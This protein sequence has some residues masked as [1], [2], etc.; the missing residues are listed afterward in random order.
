[1]R[2]HLLQPGDLPVSERK[3]KHVYRTARGDQLPAA[4]AAHRKPESEEGTR[5]EHH[6]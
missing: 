2:V 1:V 6:D 3:T 5:I 4:I